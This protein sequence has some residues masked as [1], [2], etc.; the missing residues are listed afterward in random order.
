MSKRAWAAYVVTAIGLVLWWFW[1]A[2]WV[3]KPTT[4]RLPVV[5]GA[6]VVTSAALHVYALGRFIRMVRAVCKEEELGLI[7]PGATLFAKNQRF[8]Y[9]IRVVESSIVFCIAVVA[10]LSAHDPQRFAHSPTY[11]R[12]VLTYFVGSVMAT[13][14]L[15]LR[16]LQVI[17]WARKRDQ[18][19][20]DRAIVSTVEEIRSG[21]KPSKKP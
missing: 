11:L 21:R 6:A 15:T 2:Q 5:Y 7:E 12:L 17:N 3:A 10:F 9:A 1:G 4:Y 13:G 20:L 18:E 14:V 16:D 8:R 19:R